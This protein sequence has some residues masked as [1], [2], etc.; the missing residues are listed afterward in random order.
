MEY[1]H[2]TEGARVL[3]AARLSKI[4]GEGRSRLERDDDTAQAW[5]IANGREVV[6]VSMDPGVSGG[7]ETFKRP[8][9]GPYLTE[10]LLRASYD[11][12]V[13]STMD[14]LGRNA[15]DMMRLREWAEAN[16]KR[17]TV[18]SPSLSWPPAPGDIGTPIVWD[19]LAR[20]A[21]VELD[22][23]KKRYADQRADLLANGSLVG[24]P[25]WGFE[26]V[27]V[28]GDKTLVPT[29]AKLPYLRG[30]VERALVGNTFRSIADWLNSEGVEPAQAGRPTSRQTDNGAGWSPISV[31]QILRS[32][33]LK[34]RRYNAAGQVEH[35]HTGIMSA[36]DWDILQA[37]INRPA[38]GPVTNAT[39]AL[40]G[41]AVCGICGFP[42]YV[43]RSQT[44]RKDGTVNVCEYYRCK[45]PDKAPS[46]CGNMVSREALEGFVD[47]Y[48]TTGPFAG[49]ETV[50]RVV[51]PGDDGAAEIAEVEA[52]LRDLSFDDPNFAARQASL[53]ARRAELKAAPHQ[54]SQVVERPTGRTVGALW[55]TMDD[56]TKRTHLLSAGVKVHAVSI[57]AG[58]GLP[59]RGPD[60][61]QTAFVLDGDRVKATAWLEGD[62][63]RIS[64]DLRQA[65]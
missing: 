42:M 27:G 59:A 45:G 60:R 64:A 22:T 1:T 38:R 4:S 20:L 41:A 31:R 54:P 2:S 17:I 18:L 48:L 10:P 25:C 6:A 21:Q 26:V 39:P 12:I 23:T 36:A 29:P 40:T 30:M 65:S 50:E 8:G 57:K 3:V 15:A 28:K 11:E 35:R 46:T 52:E 7:V 19:V 14:R 9:L 32:A 33:A 63:S 56:A 47:Q 16:G 24:K 5:A 37:A 53:L 55:A 13:A 49:V 34:G 61:L 58:G 62:P 51:V 44:K 43:V